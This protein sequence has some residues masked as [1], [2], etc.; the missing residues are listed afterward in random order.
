MTKNPFKT[1]EE[2]DLILRLIKDS[3]ISF[4][5]ISGLN[6]LGLN[7]DDY[8]SFLGDTIFLLMGLQHHQQSDFIFESVFLTHAEKVR[9]IDFS[10]SMEE[11]DALS[12]ETYAALEFAKG[13][14]KPE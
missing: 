3:L 11:L 13:I 2:K 7:A 1:I 8:T 4:K 14:C 9:Y 10:S 6:A 12:E 5:L